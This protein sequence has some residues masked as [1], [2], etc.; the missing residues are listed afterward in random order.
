MYRLIRNTHLLL[1]L[2]GCF[3][4]L[5]YGVS[6]VQMA[7]RNRLKIKSQTVESTLRVDLGS[8]DARRA[9]RD[10]MDRHGM[11]GELRQI[12]QHT[13]SLA[14]VISRPGSEYAVTYWPARSEARVK[15][16]TWSLPGMLEHLHRLSGFWHEAAVL[17][18]WGLMSA[19]ASGGLI[20]L[21]AT[22][23]YLWFHH[24]TE[25]LIGTILLAA[26]LGYSLTLMILI[27]LA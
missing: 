7:H 25:R 14:F 16:T 5:V 26:S 13:D 3:V 21:G 15:A 12:E 22:G 19:L 9:A 17:N 2:F 20:A 24:R 4:L 11:R 6:A 27:R 8:T 10:L 18:F 23:V 1:G